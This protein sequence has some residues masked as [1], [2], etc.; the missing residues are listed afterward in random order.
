MINT[1]AFTKISSGL[2][3]GLGLIT[4][5]Q[6]S[7]PVLA[8]SSPRVQ[9][10]QNSYVY[11]SKGSR[12]SKVSL[13]RGTY[14]KTYGKKSIKGKVYYNIGNGRYVKK[15]NTVIPPKEDKDP[16]LFTVY[17]KYDAEFYTKPNGKNSLYT[18]LGKQP[19]YETYT[20]DKGNTWYRIKYQNWVKASDTQKSK[21]KEDK[22]IPTSDNWDDP[23]DNTSIEEV[24]DELSSIPTG[25]AFDRSTIV[26]TAKCFE[27]LVN[28]W[29][30]SQGVDTKMSYTDKHFDY[31]VS[32]SIH[33]AQHFDAYHDSDRHQ[34]SSNFYGE[35]EA[36]VKEGTPQQM[37]Q[38]AFNN[39]VFYDGS[40]N[41]AHRDHLKRRSCTSFGLGLASTHKN[42]FY[43]NGVSF[44]VVTNN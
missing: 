31:D 11:S 1:K 12:K 25:T 32:R 39:F 13:K 27:K 16:V 42:G 2:L 8:A 37:A 44:V 4:I 15:I 30:A 26:E 9:L 17:L 38:E 3:I 28:D 23:N 14:L 22:D 33:D 29:R 7:S 18:L 19:V 36:L 24:K 43:E 41:F 35:L 34:G 5:Q 6:S 20:D 21:P 10:R 40:A